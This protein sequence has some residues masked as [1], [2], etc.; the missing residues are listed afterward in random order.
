MAKEIMITLV[1]LVI[2]GAVVQHNFVLRYDTVAWRF[3]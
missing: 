3:Q 2:L 1:E